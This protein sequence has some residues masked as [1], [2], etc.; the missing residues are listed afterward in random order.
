MEVRVC[1]WF[2][3]VLLNENELL[4]VQEGE[5]EVLH[6]GEAA[7]LGLEPDFLLTGS[8]LAGPRI[9]M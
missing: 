1:C 5:D 4:G 9:V 8:G 6:A 7:V 3:T 2:Y